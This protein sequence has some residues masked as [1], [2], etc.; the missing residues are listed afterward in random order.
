MSTNGWCNV[1]SIKD[2]IGKKS[3][4]GARKEE[5]VT[6]PEYKIRDT[7]TTTTYNELLAHEYE[8]AE[9]LIE[10]L[11]PSG[12][13]V[14]SAQP[15]SYKTWLLLDITISIASGTPLFGHFEAS[16]CG[17]LVIDEENSGRLLQQRLRMLTQEED[18]PIHFMIEQGF[19]L[20]DATVTKIIKVCKEKN[21]KLVTFDSLVRIHSSNENDAVQMSEVFAKIRR[22]NK[23]GVS[24]LVTHH[25]R[26]SGRTDSPSQDMRG[27]SDILA[28][29][30]CHIS[31]KRD[32]DSDRLVIT[33]TKVRSTQEL[34][35]IEIKVNTG[36]NLTFEYTG[37][38]EPQISVKTRL[39]LAINTILANRT[40]LNQ[41]DLGIALETNMKT[42]NAKTLRLVLRQMVLAEDLLEKSGKGREILYSLKGNM[43]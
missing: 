41:K 2:I 14:M 23:A 27:S 34:P 40:E 15:A 30:D 35:P 20:E 28:A 11:I 9:W 33:Q 24:V 13:T 8:E 6:I 1:D 12:L 36:D 38:L 43:A 31:V 7:L 39:K 18:L 10:G 3:R 17:V 26:K 4:T 16:Q 25:N 22:L 42:V 5:F 21:L 37:E 19:K 32:R 29:V